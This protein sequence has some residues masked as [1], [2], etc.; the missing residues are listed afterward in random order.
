MISWIQNS[1]Q[2]HFRILFFVLLAVVIVAFVFTI[3]AAPGIGQ[4]GDRIRAREFFDAN[5]GN[6]DDQERIFG[7][8]S[9]SVFL[10]AGYPALPEEQLQTY[11]LQRYAGLHLANQLNLPVPSPEQLGTFIRDL[12]AF[13]GQEGTFDPAAYARFRDSLATN[14][15]ISEG[16]V[17]RVIADDFRYRALTRLLGGP[18]HVLDAD[19][20]RQ[21]AQADSTWSINVATLDYAAYAPTI[22]PLDAILQI[23]FEGNS[24]RYEIAPQVAVRYLNFPATD[25]DDQI[26]LTEAEV[27]AFYN[28]NPTRFPQPAASDAPQL[29]F[30]TS[31]TDAEADYAAVRPQVEATLRFDRARRLAARAASDLTVVL[32]DSQLSRDAIPGW[33]AARNLELRSAPPFPRN[34]VP[35]IFGDSPQIGGEAFRLG[36][37]RAFSDALQTPTGAVILFWEETLPARIPNLAE[38][39]DRVLAD[40]VAAEKRTRFLAVGREL[41]ASLNNRISAGTAFADAITAVSEVAGLAAATAAH[42]PFTRIS[43][44]EDL[45]PTALGVLD[46][47]SAGQ[48]SEVLLSG[49]TA[50]LVHVVA[51]QVPDLSTDSP[52]F[53]EIRDRMATFTSSQSANATLNALVEA[54]L[55]KSAPALN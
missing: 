27:R 55:A 45:A 32:F 30:A 18:G 44:P 52:R 26:N 11:A 25:Y 34:A 23:Y 43:P 20:R 54:E 38:V 46:R 6:T 29:N 5:L 36:P 40:Y 12:G 15:E 7:D 1:F 3:G 42:G 28:A 50:Y 21:I 2:K 39:R 9:L 16:D 22:E 48:V 47:L 24:F 49:D 13:A 17:S 8:A 53:V 51:Q 35:G 14:P 4:A 41:T 33:V 19:V 10:Q 31:E 37:D